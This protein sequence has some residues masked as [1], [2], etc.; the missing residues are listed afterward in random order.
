[1]NIPSSF[2]LLG[3]RYTV[4]V[5]PDAEW[6]F[7]PN[8]VGWWDNDAGRVSI[9]ETSAQLMEHTFLHEVVHGCLSAM[10]RTA[11]N[12]DECFVDLLAGLLHQ[13]FKT[14]TYTPL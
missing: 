4:A 1:M 9:R 13:A 5:I 14:S 11:L 7:D 3:L 12:D 10:G 8:T 6:K 2:S